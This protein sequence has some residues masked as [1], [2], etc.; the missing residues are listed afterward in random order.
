MPELSWRELLDAR[1]FYPIFHSPIH[2]PRSH[3]VERYRSSIRDWLSGFDSEGEEAVVQ[4][5]ELVSR[6]RFSETLF[7]SIAQLLARTKALS[8][9][10]VATIQHDDW[11]NN[12]SFSPDGT[13]LVTASYDHTAK[14]YGRVNE[15]W[16][17]YSAPSK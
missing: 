9:K 11:V 7:V 12:A 4:L 2:L 6:P 17:N 15:E 10:P 1:E 5:D 8:C 16:S 14:I 3:T 13:H